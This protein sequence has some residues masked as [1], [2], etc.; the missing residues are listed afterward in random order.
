MK[1]VALAF[2]LAAGLCGAP[3]PQPTPTPAPTPEVT[4]TPEP[5]PTAFVCPS[6][7][8]ARLR[9]PCK[10][11]AERGDDQTVWD[12]TVKTDA[13]PYMPEGHPHAQECELQAMQGRPVF[14]L[15]GA[16]GTLALVERENPFQF[17]LKGRG[18]GHLVCPV[19][20][21]DPCRSQAVSR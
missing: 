20:G 14:V 1:H 6:F 2:I 13:G 3:R 21:N 12:C 17:N 16:D 10:V 19:W 5:T 18:T 4:P 7:D 11:H 15:V 8:P 9:L